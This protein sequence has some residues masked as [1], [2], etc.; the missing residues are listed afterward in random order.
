MSI[1]EIWSYNPEEAK[2]EEATQEVEE[3][4]EETVVFDE[5]AEAEQIPSE[6]AFAT[7]PNDELDSPVAGSSSV[8]PV[9]TSTSDSVSND[10]EVVDEDYG[11]GG[12]GDPE[13]D[14]LEAE[15]ARELED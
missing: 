13:L 15:I 1:D 10:Y 6:H 7:E 9:A 4:V 3:A 5:T 2:E 12:S 14:E 11:D 8:T